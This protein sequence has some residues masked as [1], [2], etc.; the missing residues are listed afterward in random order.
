MRRISSLRNLICFWGFLPALAWAQNPAPPNVV[1]GLPDC[2]RAPAFT[3]ALGFNP[4]QSAFSTTDAK[5]VGLIY[6]EVNLPST[7]RTASTP[8]PKPKV[9]QHHSWK[10]GGYLGPMIIESSGIIYIAPLPLINTLKNDPKKQNMLYRVDP[11]SAEMK[12]YFTFPMVYPPNSQNPFGILGMGYDCQT[13][14]MYLSSVQGSDRTHERGRVYAMRAGATPAVLDQIIDIDGF[15]MGIGIIEGKKKLFFG[16]ARSSDIFSVDLAED[17]KF[18]GQPQ[19]AL[20]LAGLGLRG[21][22]RARKIR[23]AENGDLTVSGVEFYFNLIAPTERQETTYIFRYN[24]QQK[25]W[26]RIG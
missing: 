1:S 3:T 25:K 17:G 13:Q 26:I 21:D 19:H 9:Y 8:P 23:F 22:D 7:N 5:Y 18:E 24:P 2:R 15:G 14:I 16:N 12:P 10:T 4:N 6:T 20:S 11:L